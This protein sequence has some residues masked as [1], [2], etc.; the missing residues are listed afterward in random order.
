M[1]DLTSS[2]PVIVSF[3]VTG[4][5]FASK[6]FL[7]L[8]CLHAKSSTVGMLSTGCDLENVPVLH[9]FINSKVILTPV[10]SLIIETSSYSVRS[11][12]VYH[13]YLVLGAPCGNDKNWLRSGR[14]E[15][16]HDT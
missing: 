7:I 10:I 8:K 2:I 5:D 15:R 12:H 11:P 14:A 6:Y 13:K 3:D 9:S 1:T 16:C 4:Q